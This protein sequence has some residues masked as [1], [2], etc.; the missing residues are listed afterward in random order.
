MKKK[1]T[2]KASRKTADHQNPPSSHEARD[3]LVVVGDFNAP[4]ISW[5]YASDSP[6]GKLVERT[7]EDLTFLS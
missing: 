4:A 5:G 7:I 6:K 2:K 3:T 1:K